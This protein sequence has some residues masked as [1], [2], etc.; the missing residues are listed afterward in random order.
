MAAGTLPAAFSPAKPFAP[1]C[2]PK[3]DGL[4]QGAQRG[5]RFSVLFGA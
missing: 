3:T 2:F 4:E 5:K 1:C